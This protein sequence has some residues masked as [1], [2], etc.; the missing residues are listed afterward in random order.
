MRP[1]VMSRY[2]FPT[3]EAKS[4]WVPMLFCL[5]MAM[6]LISQVCTVRSSAASWEYDH[7][8]S[9]QLIKG[10]IKLEEVGETPETSA[11]V[12]APQYLA[13]YK[14]VH[15]RRHRYHPARK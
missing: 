13:P 3:T 1:S 14:L 9:A 11:N 4:G 2:S 12:V 8:C 5:A 6:T 15:P 7:Q 10:N